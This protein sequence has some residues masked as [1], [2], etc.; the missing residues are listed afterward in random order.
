VATGNLQRRG[1][2]EAGRF[3]VH[4]VER[5]ALPSAERRDRRSISAIVAKMSGERRPLH[6]DTAI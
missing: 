4:G 1:V 6:F 5:E 3:A 2:Q